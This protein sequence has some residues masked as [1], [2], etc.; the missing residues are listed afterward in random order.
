MRIQLAA[1]CIENFLV[2]AIYNNNMYVLYVFT[3]ICMYACIH[4]GYLYMY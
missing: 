2:H 4:I 3:R 1:C